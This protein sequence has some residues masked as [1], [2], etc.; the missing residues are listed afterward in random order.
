MT[1]V[2]EKLNEKKEA[3]EELGEDGDPDEIKELKTRIAELEEDYE[4]FNRQTDLALTAEKKTKEQIE[5]LATKNETE[6]RSLAELTGAAPI[7]QLAAAA[8]PAPA[9]PVAEGEGVPTLPMI[10]PGIPQPTAPRAPTEPKDRP[11]AATAAQLQAHKVVEEKEKELARARFEVENYVERKRALEAQIKFE[12]DLAKTE[13]D[14]IENLEHA[15]EIWQQRLDAATEAGDDDR[16]RRSARGVKGLGDFIADAKK[17]T[18]TRVEYRESLQKR[19]GFIEE[20]GLHV[21]AVTDEKRKELEKAQR[22]L[23]WLESPV[24]PRNIAYWAME[25]G[26]RILLVVAM[27]AFLLILLRVSARGIARTFIRGRGA[28]R[29]GTG[30]ADTLAFSFRSA[31]RVMLYVIGVMLILQEAGLDLRTVL[32]GAAIFGVAIAF[33]AQDL[34]RDYF[35]GFL[36]LLEDQYQLGDLVSIGGITGTVESVNMRVTVL[37]D[38]EGRV[39]FIPNGEIK[40]VTNRTYGWG[41]P[42][43]EI[44]VG[45]DEDV[46]RVLKTLVE[47]ATELMTDPDWK[48]FVTGEPEML[49]VDKFTDR[50]MIIKFMVKTQP[51]KLFAVRREMLRR[52]AKRFHELGIQITV[53]QRLIRQEHPRRLT[54]N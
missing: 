5:A 48:P 45:F 6:K 33:G 37:R 3:L 23:F 21:N 42:V 11:S 34:M 29:S 19:L 38:L 12:K 32:G 46:D 54:L 1:E 44:P 51:D 13:A 18:E 10:P 53:P 24:H 50:G 52:I 28:R 17:A 15:L 9:A 43:F 39:H 27:I 22:S 20:E 41:R 36:I 25:R 8:E 2:T 40:A 35:T 26:P 31:A 49:G 16:A 47:V 7:P 4:L 14:E 30:R